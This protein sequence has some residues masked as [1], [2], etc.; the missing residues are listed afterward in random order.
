MRARAADLEQRAAG[1]IILL[2]RCALCALCELLRFRSRGRHGGDE[3]DE[4][5][6]DDSIMLC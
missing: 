2:E 3:D 4:H 6:V 5:D 1:A